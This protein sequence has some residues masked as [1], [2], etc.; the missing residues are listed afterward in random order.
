MTKTRQPAGMPA[1]DKTTVSREAAVEKARKAASRA[2]LKAQAAKDKAIAPLGLSAPPVPRETKAAPDH[3][4]ENNA[5]QLKT[6]KE[7][8][9]ALGVDFEEYAKAEGHDPVT[10][11]LLKSVAKTPY[12]GPM[13]ALAAA[14]RSYVKAANGVQCN[15]DKLATLCGAHPRE[16]TVAA[17]ILAMNLGHNPYLHLNPGQQSMNLRNKARHQVSSGMLSFAA[18]Q[19]AYDE[20]KAG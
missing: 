14:R 3:T 1:K 2:A 8:A 10:G 18:I 17:L 5:N 19:R 20:Y 12:S 16:A 15:G 13:L 11:A 4:A 6:L 9:D 7:D